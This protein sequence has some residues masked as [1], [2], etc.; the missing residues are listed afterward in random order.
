[1]SAE[2]PTGDP[3]DSRPTDGGPTDRGPTDG[4]RP[5]LRLIRGDATDEEIAVILALLAA[6]G[7][8]AR[9][10][11]TAREATSLWPAASHAHRRSRSTYQAHR[12]GWRTSLWPH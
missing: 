6:R 7:R 5:T 10:Q 8:A 2:K 3:T 12:H 9:V 1:V 4:G 11:E